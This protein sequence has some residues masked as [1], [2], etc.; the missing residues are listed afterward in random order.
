M[1]F[2][3]LS[4][5][6]SKPRPVM[7][8]PVRLCLEALETRDC[9]SPTITSFSATPLNDGTRNVE[10]KG[11]VSDMNP[12][13]DF[14]QFSGVVNGSASVN[15]NG[16]FDVIKAASYLGTVSATAMSPFGSS[17]PAYASISVAGP[18]ITS[19]VVIVG[20]AG[21]YTF[22]GH[23]NAVSPQG[24]MV[25]FGGCPGVGGITTTDANGNF[26]VTYVLGMVRGGITA[27]ATDIWGQASA[28]FYD[29][30]V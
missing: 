17:S 29:P 3:L 18:V 5:V 9:P 15:S 20:P 28:P 16:S 7:R 2:G 4:A 21:T 24:N 22:E 13:S 25:S 23:V 1:L 10:L 12:T 11:T 14:V 30:L 8:K 26:D 19:F 27:I 6:R